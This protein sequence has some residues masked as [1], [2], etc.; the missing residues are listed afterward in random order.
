MR[1]SFIFKQSTAPLTVF[2]AAL[3]FSHSYTL[4]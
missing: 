4:S 3:W 2:N 1:E